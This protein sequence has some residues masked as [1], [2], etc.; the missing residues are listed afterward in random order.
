MSF[1]LVSGTSLLKCSFGMAPS[2]FMIVP[3]TRTVLAE[4][5]F[6]GN[7]SDVIPIANITTFT[8]CTS[9]LN[10][11]VAAATA[12]AGTLVPMPCIPVPVTPW[13]SAALNVLVQG[14]P[15]IDQTAMVMCTWAGMITIV[16]PGNF[17]VLVP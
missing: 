17:T 2:A 1:A 16:Q 7:I 10:P 8:L 6:M 15:A 5:M 4:F 9:L 13:I 12:A 14:F 3:G 11:A